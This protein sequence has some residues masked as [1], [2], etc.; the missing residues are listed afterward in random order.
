VLSV[1]G[2]NF[3]CDVQFLDRKPVHLRALPKMSKEESLS[4]QKEDHDHYS[5]CC[6]V[7]EVGV[8]YD[9][10]SR[11]RRTM[12]DAHIVI[13]KFGGV[14]SQGYFAVYDGHGGRGAVEFVVEQLH[15]NLLKELEKHPDNSVEALKQAYLVTD[16]Q[17]G[18]NHVPA[19]TT[20]VSALVRVDKD[21]KRRLLIANAGDSRAVLCR[22]TQAIRLS[23]DHKGSDETETK[24][25]T[26]LGGFVLL[27]RV[28]GILAVTRS[29]GDSAMKEFV[30]G[31]PHTAVVE[32]TPEDT[33]LILACDGLWDVVSDQESMDLIT[34]ESN[35][36]KMSEKL[37]S[38]ALKKGST[39][40][41]SIM[42]IVL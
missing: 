18:D 11:F 8:S 29:L 31:E 30:T 10:N 17:I 7:K 4:H 35:P 22:K 40:N 34:S 9:T 32:L 14:E 37:L 26:D 20:A 19:G 42:V 39:D 1:L 24:R 28:N 12:E 13:D 6:S 23:Y 33:H 16:K 38:H 25:I 3:F 21:G 15:T 36:K 2:D 41:I 27:N 5:N